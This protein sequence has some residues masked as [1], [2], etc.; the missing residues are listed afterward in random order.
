MYL[1]LKIDVIITLNAIGSI[2]KSFFLA[3]LT[4]IFKNMHTNLA[5][6]LSK[7]YCVSI[8]NKSCLKIF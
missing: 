8:F 7:R 2:F 1:A 3:L 5:K 4:F 6:N